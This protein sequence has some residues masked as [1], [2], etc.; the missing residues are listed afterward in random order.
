MEY[1]HYYAPILYLAQQLCNQKPT[2]NT[3]E[4][5]TVLTQSSSRIRDQAQ[6]DDA[7]TKEL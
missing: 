1:P 6:T 3:R 4:Y 2:P 7:S 5:A